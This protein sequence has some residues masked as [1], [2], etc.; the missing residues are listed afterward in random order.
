M[1]CVLTFLSLSLP[2]CVCLCG[3][4]CRATLLPLPIRKQSRPF[5]GTP[6]AP[7]AMFPSCMA[8]ATW[9]GCPTVTLTRSTWE[10]WMLP[11]VTGSS[12][13]SGMTRSL[14]VRPPVSWAPG[15][16]T[17]TLGTRRGHSHIGHQ[18]GSLPHWAPGGVTPTLGTRSGHSHIG[19]QEGS[20]PHWAPGGITPTLGTRRGHSH[21]GH[22][23][24][25]LPHWAPGGVTPTLGTR[26]GHS[27]IGHQE[28]SLPHW[29]PGAVTPTLGTRRCHS[30]I[31]HQEGSLP[32]WAPG[33]VTPTLG[34]RRGHSHM[35]CACVYVHCLCNGNC[36]WVDSATSVCCDDMA[37]PSVS[38][39]LVGSG[40]GLTQ[41]VSE[42]PLW[43]SG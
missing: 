13:A 43:V 20:L 34:T 32:H 3:T 14:K 39:V 24:G 26:R 31:G 15:G 30:H 28:G 23:E 35:V 29:A 25:S 42:G 22:Q 21:I 36:D 11:G 17:P 18:E 38:T 40:T 7:P 2:L 27:H 6:T 41:V 5:W 33:G 8:W 9:S 4:R 37:A 1:G 12:P 10:G 16:V 19:H